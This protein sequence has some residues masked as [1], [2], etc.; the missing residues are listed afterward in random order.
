VVETTSLL[1]MC[2]EVP[3]LSDQ[4]AA[5]VQAVFNRQRTAFVEVSDHE[6]HYATSGA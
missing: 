4:H 5:R 3:G 1:G 2:A 6:A